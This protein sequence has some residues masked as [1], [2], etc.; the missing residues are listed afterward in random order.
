MKMP[1]KALQ[2]LKKAANVPVL[3][4]CNER[5]ATPTVTS[6]V[7]SIFLAVN[8]KRL[9]APRTAYVTCHISKMLMQARHTPISF[10][11]PYR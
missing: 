11:N 8:P 2:A 10:S 1:Q 7:N 3:I 9:H 6:F 5:F 4:T